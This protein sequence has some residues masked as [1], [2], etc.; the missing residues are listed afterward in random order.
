MSLTVQIIGFNLCAVSYNFLHEDAFDGSLLPL[1]T[2]HKAVWAY[3]I[4]KAKPHHGAIGGGA[5]RLVPRLMAVYFSDQKLEDIESVIDAFCAP[6]LDTRTEAHEGRKL[7]PMGRDLYAI[8]TYSTHAGSRLA[9]DAER[10]RRE[11]ANEPEGFGAPQMDGRRVVERRQGNGANEVGALPRDHANHRLC[12]GPLSKVC[13]T[14]NQFDALAKRLIGSKPD[15]V[16][17]SLEQFRTHL[18]AQIPEGTFAGDM[19]WLLKHFD[20]WMV[21]SGRVAP[22]PQRKKPSGRSMVEILAERDAKKAMASR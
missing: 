14:Y 2:L 21:E 20:A 16:E 22:E 13:F 11:R 18:A 3:I 8:P 7:L 17:T 15:D 9:R 6:D 4:A 19:M 10:K 12:G 1:P 5:V